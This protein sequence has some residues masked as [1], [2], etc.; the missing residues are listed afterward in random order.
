MSSGDGSAGAPAV[1]SAAPSSPGY[2]NTITNFFT[3]LK[4]DASGMAIRVEDQVL[5]AV[6]AGMDRV[7]SRAK[8]LT[9]SLSTLTSAEARQSAM[10][11]LT[12]QTSAIERMFG[13]DH[14][15][16]SASGGVASFAHSVEKAMDGYDV[17]HAHH[18]ARATRVEQLA[19]DLNVRLRSHVDVWRRLDED[20][21]ALPSA[22]SKAWEMKK[23]ATDACA[24][25]DDVEQMLLEAELA[26]KIDELYERDAQAQELRRAAKA[27]HKLELERLDAF[28]R[29]AE[30]AAADYAVTQKSREEIALEEEL[31]RDL[32]AIKK[33]KGGPRGKNK[34]GS[35]AF[36]PAPQAQDH[37][38]LG[39]PLPR[40]AAEKDDPNED[41]AAAADSDA[42]DS[43][44]SFFDGGD[45]KTHPRERKRDPKAPA[46]SSS[47]ADAASQID[48]AG[49][50]RAMADD[51]DDFLA[52]DDDDDA[53]E[54]EGG[55]A[56][57]SGAPSSSRRYYTVYGLRKQADESRAKIAREELA[58]ESRSAAAWL[59]SR[60]REAAEAIGLARKEHYG[61]EDED[62][63]FVNLKPPP[64]SGGAGADVLE[65]ED[66]P[67]TGPGN[68]PP[69]DSASGGI[70]AAAE[71]VTGALT[72]ASAAM[73]SAAAAAS[74]AAAK[75]AS[76]F[77]AFGTSLFASAEAS[78]EAAR[79]RSEALAEAARKRSEESAAWVGAA[80]VAGGERWREHLQGGGA[81]AEPPGT[82]E[83][84]KTKTTRTSSGEGEEVP[85]TPA[86]SEGVSSV[87]SSG[88]P[89]PVSSGTPI[90]EEAT[91]TAASSG[92][93]PV[94]E[95]A[96]FFDAEEEEEEPEPE[97]S[98][99][100]N[101]S[102][103]LSLG[104]RWIDRRLRL[105]RRRRGVTAVAGRRRRRRT[106]RRRR[107]TERI[108]TRAS[109]R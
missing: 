23:I 7:E 48:V 9:T 99:S 63:V 52:D 20:L 29:T 13:E 2:L 46:G 55:A 17:T 71:S 38:G 51:L 86:E 43:D 87:I 76:S 60:S 3:S 22:V 34:D 72:S 78:L 59:N 15:A 107:R 109:T 41:A 73:E 104:R 106:L 35:D 44:A 8:S 50:V 10:A 79:K 102:L 19:G 103:S 64:P 108:A 70:G 40:D 83:K 14:H 69:A 12:R 97:P 54:G 53:E 37:Y 105:N 89:P 25:L 82:E 90:A 31:R 92:A 24:A 39:A 42:S 58:L 84:T 96:E 94:A 67:A 49:S 33:K 32:R 30:A 80:V 61:L 18:L 81:S 45:P 36:I 4:V 16:T 101:L 21:A 56:G 74:S 1:A 5:D 77:T 100:P 47:L 65:E 28:R 26:V 57:D 68:P 98:P 75:A 88:T 6:E 91:P 95:E 27:A 93:T 62:L 66:A 85:G 11:G